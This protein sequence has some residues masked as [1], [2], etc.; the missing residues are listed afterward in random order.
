ML[1]FPSVEV[2]KLSKIYKQNNYS[3]IVFDSVET[4][5]KYFLT[6]QAIETY[7]QFCYKQE[8]KLADNNKSLHW[9]ISF[10]LNTKPTDPNYVP[11][12]DKWRDEKNR[13]T[14]MDL[15]FQQGNHPDIVH[16]P[17]HLF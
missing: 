16:D 5:K 12:A 9:T 3:D 17:K 4:A 13:I 6:N 8:W 11:N 7:N 1:N 14:S 10:E 2:N 15:W